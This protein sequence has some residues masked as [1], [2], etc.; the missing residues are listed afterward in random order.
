MKK[1]RNSL[2]VFKPT[3]LLKRQLV[4]IFGGASADLHC[5]CSGSVGCWYYPGTAGGG[6]NDI[7][8]NADINRKCG[9]HPDTGTPA[10]ECA[11]SSSWCLTA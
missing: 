6:G 11:Y 1:I 3:E 5:R 4:A 2:N 7:D 9:P 8:V 10:G